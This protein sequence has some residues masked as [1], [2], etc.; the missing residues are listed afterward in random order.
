MKKTACSLLAGILVCSMVVPTFAENKTNAQMRTDFV[1][2]IDGEK[3]LFTQKDGNVSLPI[4]YK[5]I[6]YLP[7]HEIGQIMGKNAKWDENTKTIILS[8]NREEADENIN[9]VSSEIK[10]IMVQEISDFTI[11]VDGKESKISS[12]SRINPIVYNGSIY[13]SLRAIGE[14]IDKDIAWN[15]DTK[16]V[17]ITSKGSSLRGKNRIKT[18]YHSVQMSNK[19]ESDQIGIEKAKE[20]ALNHAELNEKQVRIKMEM[21]DVIDIYRVQFYFDTK[22][23]DYK[24]DAETGKVLSADSQNIKSDGIEKREQISIEEAKNIAFS[25]ANVDKNQATIRRATLHKERDKDIYNLDFDTTDA[26]YAYKINASDGKVIVALLDKYKFESNVGQE[27]I[28]MDEAKKIALDYAGVL[29]KDTEFN[30]TELYL[31]NYLNRYAI[32][33]Q[34]GEDTYQFFIDAATGDIIF[35]KKECL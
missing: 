4:L 14:M 30:L 18:D 35:F 16:S 26:E 1:I 8:G 25:H 29:K 12:G 17:S 2:E 24:I 20:I 27:P 28:T 31:D 32:V 7:L 21:E 19:Y 13:L 23:Y 11:E 9:T 10:D 6:T 3:C 33:F 22:K 5:G 34:N 15:G